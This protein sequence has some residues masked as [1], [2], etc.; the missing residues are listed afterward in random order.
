[1]GGDGEP[2]LGSRIPPRGE[3]P[4][5]HVYLRDRQD[6]DPGPRRL[7]NES[8]GAT[9]PGRAEHENGYD[10]LLSQALDEVE[11]PSAALLQPEIIQGDA[12]PVVEVFES[13]SRR[14]KRDAAGHFSRSSGRAARHLGLHH[15]DVRPWFI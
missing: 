15:W 1:M 5:L 2:C 13:I 4:G 12:Y 7:V 8:H 6:A 11:E 3:V 14:Q 10:A 9:Y